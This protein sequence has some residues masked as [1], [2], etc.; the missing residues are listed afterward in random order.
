MSK[1]VEIRDSI[2]QTLKVE[3]VTEELKTKVTQSII[4]NVF[5]AIEEAVANFVTKVREQAPNETGWCRI[6]DGIVLPL[7]LEGLVFVA[8]TVLAKS[9]AA[10]V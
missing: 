3:E 1:W 2:V 5:P 8:K 6:R 9:L 4:D 7:V 10:K